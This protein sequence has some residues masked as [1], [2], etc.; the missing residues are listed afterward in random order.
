MAPNGP[1]LLHSHPWVISSH[2]VYGWSMWPTE[3][4]RNDGLS[5]PRLG[6]ERLWPPCFASFLSLESFTL[7]KD[8]HV[9]RTL[10]QAIESL[11]AEDQRAPDDGQELKL[12]NSR[13]SQLGTGPP[14][15]GDLMKE[16]DH[17]QPAKSL[18]DSPP[19]ET[20]WHHKG[21]CLKLQNLGG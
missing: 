3:Y 16:C 6:Y 20:K 15:P 21:Y 13:M 17:S 1:H 10:R 7:E 5:L 2:T 8:D 11:C 9:L 4:S 12:T 19:S 18:L 14:A